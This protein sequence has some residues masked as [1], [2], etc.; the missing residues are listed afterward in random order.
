MSVRLIFDRELCV[1]HAQCFATSPEI[2][3]IDDDGYC[4]VADHDVAEEDLEA[5][6]A[7]AAACPERALSVEPR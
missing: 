3:P 2:F 1:G 4:I 7:G 5:T 6:R